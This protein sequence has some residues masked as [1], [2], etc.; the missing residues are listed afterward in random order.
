[1]SDFLLRVTGLFDKRYRDMGDGSHAEVVA[2]GTAPAAAADCVVSAPGAAAVRTLAATPGRRHYLPRV[3]FGYS[4]TPPAGATLTITDG[5]ALVYSVPVTSEG[6]GP[7]ELHIH[8]AAENTAMVIT[9]SAGG[10]TIVAHVN[11]PG[12]RTE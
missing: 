9:L 5:G 11:T 2:L 1:M 12:A 10:G 7:L 4:A 8:S 3:H 6:P